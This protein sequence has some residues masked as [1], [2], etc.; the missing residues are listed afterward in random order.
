[1]IILQS[2]PRNQVTCGGYTWDE[3][4]VLPYES[5]RSLIN[6]FSVLNRISL[7]DCKN[8]FKVERKED[9]VSELGYSLSPRKLALVIGLGS[10]LDGHLTHKIV[11]TSERNSLLSPYIRECPTCSLFGYHCIFHQLLSVTKCPIHHVNLSISTC[12]LCGTH[13]VY[14][15]MRI[16]AGTYAGSPDVCTKCGNKLRHLY[17]ETGRSPERNLLRITDE[18]KAALDALYEWLVASRKIA[19]YGQ[20]LDRW[21]RMTEPLSFPPPIGRIEHKK[22]LQ[23]LRG[24][25]VMA[26]RGLLIGVVPPVSISGRAGRHINYSRVQYGFGGGRTTNHNSRSISS[27]EPKLDDSGIIC[28]EGDNALQKSLS[29]VY[30]SIR[31]HIAKT[32]LRTQHTRCA[33]V[34]EKAMWWEPGSD[35]NIEMCPWAFSYLFWRRYWEK[36]PR[37]NQRNRYVNWKHFLSVNI[38]ANDRSLNE[39]ASLRIFALEC[40]WTFQECVLLARGM[41]R[42]NKFRWDFGYIRGRLLPYWHLDNQTYP[43]EVSIAWWNRQPIHSRT[44]R[45]NGSSRQHRKDVSVQAKVIEHDH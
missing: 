13:A 25:E 39:W 5:L 22:S 31:R 41:R 27:F 9:G 32:F 18:H 35:S 37:T 36:Q 24:C 12:S 44:L 7:S 6:K 1:M 3:S 33:H 40:Y 19:A 2:T 10:E 17:D 8:I 28:S 34:V 15:S 42:E 16:T 20:N 11:H 29:P 38:S 23:Q 43:G 14:D 21:E 30:K 26:F 45:L 4:W